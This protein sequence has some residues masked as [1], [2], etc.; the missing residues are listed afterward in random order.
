MLHRG[1]L[2]VERTMVAPFGFAHSIGVDARFPMG[3]RLPPVTGKIPG[4]T[5]STA[6]ECA[7]RIASGRGEDQKR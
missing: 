1:S 4:T 3:R 6:K 5:G 2:V 7:E